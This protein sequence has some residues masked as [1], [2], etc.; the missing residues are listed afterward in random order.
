MSEVNDVDWLKSKPACAT[1]WSCTERALCFRVAL[2]SIKQNQIQR[3][4]NSTRRGILL[5]F[6]NGRYLMI[7]HREI[8]WS[9]VSLAFSER[10]HT[11]KNNPT[12]S[13]KR[14]FQPAWNGSVAAASGLDEE[15]GIFCYDG[16]IDPAAF[17]L[18][19][20]GVS[21]ITHKALVLIAG[22]S[23]SRRWW[24]EEECEV[25]EGEERGVLKQRLQAAKNLDSL[26]W[27]TGEG[28][29]PI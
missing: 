12:T 4:T 29:I 23:A 22:P 15:R 5:S 28:E 21:H 18:L 13:H 10:T 1:V 7:F 9:W 8:G 16:C 17:E 14:Y 26:S 11:R 25:G 20:G 24:M 19:L 3:K 2:W 27:K 6:L